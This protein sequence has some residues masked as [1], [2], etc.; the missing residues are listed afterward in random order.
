VNTATAYGRRQV[1]DLALD[2]AVT[3][4]GRAAVRARLEQRIGAEE[5]PAGRRDLV[6]GEVAHRRVGRAQAEQMVPALLDDDHRPARGSQ[7]VGDRRPAR[8]GADDDR[9]AVAH[10]G[11][12]RAGGKSGS[13][14]AMRCQPPE[15]RLPP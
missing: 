1:V 6:V 12:V 3:V 2:E 13:G 5:V 11:S 8:T 9:V 7:H 15:S 14:N 10:E 4:G